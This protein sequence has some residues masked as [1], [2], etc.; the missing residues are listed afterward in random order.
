M[1]GVLQILGIIIFIRT[2]FLISGVTGGEF[3]FLLM[4]VTIVPA[5]GII[6]TIN[7]IGVTIFIVKQKPRGK[8]LVFCI[9]SILISLP[10]AWLIAMSLIPR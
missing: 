2:L 1:L 10:L 7:L 9:I 6:A 4:L 3:V 8:N 5:Q